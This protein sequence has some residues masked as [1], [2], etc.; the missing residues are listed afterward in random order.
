M[1]RII[2]E[3]LHNLKVEYGNVLSGTFVTEELLD[4]VILQI[5]EHHI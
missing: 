5:L 4:I 3:G 1:Y 2:E